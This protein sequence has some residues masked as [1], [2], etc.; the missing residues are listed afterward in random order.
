MSAK[1][2]DRRLAVKGDAIC[3]DFLKSDP[4]VYF[5]YIAAPGNLSEVLGEPSSLIRRIKSSVNG[6]SQAPGDDAS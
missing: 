3:F 1:N 4:A 5:D 6:L 2:V